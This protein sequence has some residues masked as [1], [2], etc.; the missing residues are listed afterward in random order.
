[1]KRD[2][3]VFQGWQQNGRGIPDPEGYNA[4]DYFSTSGEYLGPDEDGIEP[5]FEEIQTK[6]TA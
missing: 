3:A 4:W 5:I 1:M 6:P 2:N